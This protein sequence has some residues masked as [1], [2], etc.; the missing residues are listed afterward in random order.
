MIDHLAFLFHR[1]NPWLPWWQEVILNWVSTWP[2]I[3]ILL[4]ASPDGDDSCQ[5]NDDYD[6][7]RQKLES[8]LQIDP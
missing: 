1:A 8:L 7:M 5:W 3:S 4:V 2:A 6:A